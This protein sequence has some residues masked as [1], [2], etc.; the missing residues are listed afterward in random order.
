[1]LLY[2]SESGGDLIDV[3]LPKSA[4]LKTL[5]T[6]LPWTDGWEDA[7]IGVQNGEEQL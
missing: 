6:I 1:M 3:K 7:H 5:L 2:N 4:R